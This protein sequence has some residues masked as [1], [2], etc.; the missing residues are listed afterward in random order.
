MKDVL[1]ALLKRYVA[2]Q[3]ISTMRDIYSE[4]PGGA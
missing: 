2:R 3:I 1:P 4:R